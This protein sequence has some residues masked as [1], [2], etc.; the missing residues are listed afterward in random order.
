MWSWVGAPL[1]LAAVLSPSGPRTPSYASE[2]ALARYARGRLLEEQGQPME[3]LGEYYRGLLLDER[4]PATPP[5]ERGCPRVSASER[6]LGFANGALA[7]D[8][9]TRTA[10]GSRAPHC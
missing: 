2:E 5:R 7:A 6:S 8:S 10:G 9:S 4:S 1:V 3:A